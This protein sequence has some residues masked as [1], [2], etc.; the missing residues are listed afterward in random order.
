MDTD[1]AKTDGEGNTNKGTATGVPTQIVPGTG[2]ALT[3]SEQGVARMDMVATVRVDSLSRTDCPWW[4]ST[5]TENDSRE[6]LAQTTAEVI[7]KAAMVLRVV[8]AA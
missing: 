8:L 6:P 1:V 7:L 4:R 3:W 2:T 5:V